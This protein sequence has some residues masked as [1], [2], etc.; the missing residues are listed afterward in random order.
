MKGGIGMKVRDL[1]T[2]IADS[3]Q[4]I[5]IKEYKNSNFT[6]REWTIEPHQMIL[7]NIPVDILNKEISMIVPYYSYISILIE[8]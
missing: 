3:Y 5:E 8:K 6:G 4:R 1:L 7:K 2:I